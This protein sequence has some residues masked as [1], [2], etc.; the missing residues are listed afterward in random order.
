MVNFL[1]IQQ[2]INAVVIVVIQT[3][4]EILVKFVEQHVHREQLFLIVIQQLV[5]VQVHS[6]HWLLVVLSVILLRVDL[7]VNLIQKPVHDV[8]VNQ[9]IAVTVVQTVIGS[10]PTM[11]L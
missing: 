7:M 8:Y 5:D 3:G 6:K 9:T 1:V 10:V 4:K 2:L 11:E